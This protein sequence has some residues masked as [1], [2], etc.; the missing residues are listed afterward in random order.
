MVVTVEPPATDVGVSVLKSGGNAVDAAVAVGLALAVTHPS[1]GN[2]GGGGFMLIRFADGRSTF[3]DFRERAPAKATP[4]MY[5]GKDGKPTKDSDIGYL[6]SGIPGTVRGFE[7]AQREYGRQKWHEVVQPAWRLADQGFVVSSGLARQLKAKANQE[8]LS[9]FSESKR[10]FLRD[11]RLYQPGELFVQPDLARTL[12][13]LMKAGAADFYEGE[14]ARLLTSDMQAHGGLITIEDLRQYQAV[15]R[16]PLTGL[17]RGYTIITAP[18]P[19]SGGF[20][21]LQILGMLEPSGFA[22]SGTGSPQ[23]THYMAEA[24][25]RFFADRSRYIGDPDFCRVPGF[26]LNPEYIAARR[27][28]IDPEHAAPSETIAAGSAPAHESQQT[29]HYSVIDTAGN[30]VAVTYTLNGS[31]GSGVTVP[32][33]GFL[34]NNEMDDFSTNPGATNQYGLTYS[35]DVNSIQ[36]HKIPLSSMSPTIVLH[37]GKLYAVLGSPGGPT[38]INTV[39]EVLVNLIDFKMNVA[40]AV[41]AP[42]FHHQWKPD[43]LQVERG[44]SPETIARLRSMGHKVEVIRE[45]GE[46]AAIVVEAGGLEGA[47]DLRTEGTAAGY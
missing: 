10:I 21:I 18:P 3:I 23:A 28:T 47:A 30:A 5:L 13:R 25:R 33:T 14:T 44:F 46:V 19:S 29:T 36:P 40:D 32:G 2:L 43:Q 7:L 34:L 35:G 37:N 1:A 22:H 39:L 42:R 6:A 11:G 38:I 15:E 24:M 45:Q 4:D 12:K 26:L 8:R 16:T 41:D 27:R 31:Y 17:Y 20:G 9:R